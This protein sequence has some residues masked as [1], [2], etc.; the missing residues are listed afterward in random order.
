MQTGP[1]GALL[2]VAAAGGEVLV[3]FVQHYVVKVDLATREV[4]LDPP[5]GL[6]DD[7]AL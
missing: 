6:F 3:P 7:D 1:G 2:T 4:V 5:R